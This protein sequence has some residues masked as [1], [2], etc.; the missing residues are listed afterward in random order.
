MVSETLRDRAAMVADILLNQL[1]SLI[2]PSDETLGKMEEAEKLVKSY[3]YKRFEEDFKRETFQGIAADDF[4]EFVGKL[5]VRFSLDGSTKES[6][7]EILS[8]DAGQTHKSDILF[9][10]ENDMIHYHEII[11]MK[12]DGKINLGII[13]Y[14]LKYEFDSMNEWWPWLS[15]CFPFIKHKVTGDEESLTMN[16]DHKDKLEKWCQVKSFQFIDRE[17]QNCELED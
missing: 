8:M 4:E 5:K 12:I 7:L 3:T 6:L 16:E 17:H 15:G 13:T 10:E 2:K 14:T 11:V 9:D 1:R